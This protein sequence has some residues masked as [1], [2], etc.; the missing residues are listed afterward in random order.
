MKETQQVEAAEAK[1]RITLRGS[2]HAG[3]QWAVDQTDNMHKQAVYSA[4]ISKIAAIIVRI[5]KALET[6]RNHS[7]TAKQI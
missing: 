4:E 1:R 6:C 7:T 2:V 3:R 5:S